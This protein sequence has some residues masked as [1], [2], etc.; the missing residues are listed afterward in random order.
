MSAQLVTRTGDIS[1]NTVNLFETVAA[2]LRNA[3]QRE[4]FVFRI[5]GAE[6][7]DLGTRP[8]GLAGGGKPQRA[9]CPVLV[10]VR[11][12]WK[13][14]FAALTGPSRCRWRQS[15][16]PAGARPE[17]DTVLICHHGARSFQVALFLNATDFPRS[18]TFPAGIDA[19][20]RDVDAT[21]PKY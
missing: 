6:C 12:P 3:Q 11:E 9:S 10:D 1:F 17:R 19:W 14:R 18:S 21:M 5:S 2:P 20:S 7:A 16:A 4:R 8:G 15:R 13:R